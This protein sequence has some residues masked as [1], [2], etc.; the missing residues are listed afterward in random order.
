MPRLLGSAPQGM[1]ANDLLR[2]GYIEIAPSTTDEKNISMLCDDHL[3]YI[4]FHAFPDESEENAARTTIDCAAAFGVPNG[5][6][7][8]GR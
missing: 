4:W 6:M 1:A 5:R 7:S 8:D 2:F 3:N